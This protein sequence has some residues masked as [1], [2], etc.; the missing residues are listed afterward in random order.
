[1][2]WFILARLLFVGAVSYSA[3]LLRPVGPDPL[4]N[5]AFGF[6]LAGLAV[7]FE[8]QLRATSVAHMLGALLG[9]TIGLFIA[10]GIGAAL[11]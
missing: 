3:F 11:Y 4:I 6:G 5:L 8:W 1:M 2:A 10:K 9:E 7:A